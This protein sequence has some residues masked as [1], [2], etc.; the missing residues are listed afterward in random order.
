MN[1]LNFSLSL[2][3]DGSA[4]FIE[5]G[6]GRRGTRSRVDLIERPLRRLSE[7]VWRRYCCPPIM[8]TR[9]LCVYSK[10]LA[11]AEFHINYHSTW[12]QQPTTQTKVGLVYTSGGEDEA[13]TEL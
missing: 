1:S 11:L 5:G 8:K 4:A 13:Q 7:T 9:T 2:Y 6:Q 12:H 3:C 10:R